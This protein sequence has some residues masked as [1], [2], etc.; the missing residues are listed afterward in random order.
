MSGLR[1]RLLRVFVL[2]WIAG[3]ATV[4][5]QTMD[6]VYLHVRDSDG[7]KPKSGATVALTFKGGVTGSLALSAVQP[8]ETVTDTGTYAVRNNLI[9]IHFKEMEW[10]ANR[11]PFQFDGCTLTLPFKALGG[12]AGPGTSVWLKKDPKC[13]G[14]MVTNKTP[15]NGKFAP[16]S[17]DE[18]VTTGGQR[19]RSRIYAAEKAI[20]GEVDENGRKSVTIFRLDRDAIWVLHMQQKTYTEST[21][22]YGT[23]GTLAREQSTPPGCRVVGE[24]KVSGFLAT[25]EECLIPIPNKKYIETNWVAKELGGV[26]IKQVSGNQTMEFENIK[27]ESL[28]PALFEIPAGF[29]KV[30]Q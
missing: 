21:L 13:G 8:G 25:K 18:I 5:A 11:Q 1:S 19:K 17:A 16:F 14:Q 6:G 12:S 10:E 27:R 29:R 9:T 23:G 28:D 2:A 7:T 15:A 20:R 26:M 22:G 3:I 4:A 30:S 24:E